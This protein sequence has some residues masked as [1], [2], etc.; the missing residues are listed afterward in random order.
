[1]PDLSLAV[2]TAGIEGA[3]VW[4]ALP[5]IRSQ[6]K[7]GATRPSLRSRGLGSHV[8]DGYAVTWRETTG[9]TVFSRRLKRAFDC[10][11]W[12]EYGA[13]IF[14]LNRPNRSRL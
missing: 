10:I 13:T 1:M 8:L 3:G 12:G 2:P 4:V 6:V 5:A 11:F 9:K 7:L 14:F